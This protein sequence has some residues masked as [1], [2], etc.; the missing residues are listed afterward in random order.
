MS[1]SQT[2]STAPR[3]DP[4][5]A[6]RVA[7]FAEMPPMRQRGLAAVRE[8]LESQSARL[9][10]QRATLQQ[11]LELVRLAEHLDTLF[12]RFCIGK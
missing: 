5:A 10:C 6:A 3:L 4:D 9:C 12:A 7:Q 2:Q 8:A 1:A 11:R